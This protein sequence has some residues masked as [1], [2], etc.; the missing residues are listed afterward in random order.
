MH[1]FAWLIGASTIA[2]SIAAAPQAAA[3]RITDEMIVTATKREE[4]AQNVPIAI[5]TYSGELAKAAGV[6]DIRELSILSPSLIVVATQSEAVG[7][8]ARIRGVGTVGDNP[9]LQ[10]SVGVFIDEVYRSRNSVALGDLGEIDAIEVARGPQGTLFGRNSSVGAIIV[11][12]KKPEFERSG[13]LEYTRANYN[14]NRV[15]GAVTGGLTDTL[16]GRFYGFFEDRDGFLTDVDTGRKYNDRNQWALRGQLLWEPTD[17]FT[18]RLIGDYSKRDE[19]CCASAIKVLGPTTGIVTALGG[20]QAEFAT[21]PVPGRPGSFFGRPFDR[22]TALTANRNLTQDVEEYG[23]SLQA[24]WNAGFADV[25]SITSYRDFK[26]SRSQDSDLS[27]LDILF[28]PENGFVNEFKTFTQELR[29]TGETSFFDWLVGVY[30]SQEKGTLNDRLSFGTDY[31]AYTSTLVNA[32][33][34]G[35]GS[36]AA[37]TFSFAG[38]TGLPAGSVFAGVGENDSWKTDTRSIAVFSNENFHLTD[39]LTL[40][41]GGRYTNENIDFDGV[42]SSSNNGCLATLAEIGRIQGGMPSSI[43]N[44]LAAQAAGSTIAALG[45]L[46][47]IAPLNDGNFSDTRKES[48]FTGEAK[49]TAVLTNNINLYGGYARGYKSGGYNFDRAGF[50]LIITGNVPTADQ[51]EFA[52]EITNSI[53]GGFKTTWFNGNMT[54]NITGFRM[55][56]D[57]YQLNTFNGINFVVE[58]IN[59][60]KSTGAEFDLLASPSDKIFLQG[61][62]TYADTR[63]TDNTG[64]SI[65]NGTN[66]RTLDGQ[67]ITLAPLWSASGA[68]TYTDQIPNTNY[69]FWTSLN[70]R[71]SSSY[72]TGSDLD[73]NKE[74]GDF[75]VFNSSIGLRTLGKGIEVEAFVHNLFDTQITQVAFNQPLQN[76]TFGVFLAD[77]RTYGITLRARF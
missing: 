48:Q 16:A 45:C 72:N 5:S 37:G 23:T 63:Y 64:S 76:G 71:Y 11:R 68:V 55:N 15:E 30:F 67:R 44:A 8:N 13:Y 49:L 6:T 60:V 52:E 10:S 12:T 40:T 32:A 36:P 59:K 73:P 27:S 26:V 51:L 62:V 17:T 65:V 31:E 41:L 1:K 61:G 34:A 66:G 35:A 53:E 21:Q 43:N 20:T 56:I 69:E 2:V 75:V 29:A 50:P 18:A 47:N 38:F 22:E 54:A 39:R 58:N 74:Q 4:N 24:N 28:R 25:V 46:V 57:D 3:Q 19:V 70:G 77:P 14:G 42:A 33:L 9:G 7:V